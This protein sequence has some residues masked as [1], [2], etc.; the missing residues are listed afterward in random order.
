MQISDMRTTYMCVDDVRDSV[1]WS[2]GE[3]EELQL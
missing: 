1:K 3:E 2:E